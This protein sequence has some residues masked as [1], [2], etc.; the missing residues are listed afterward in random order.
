M[1]IS[2]SNT[3]SESQPVNIK[4]GHVTAVP[5]RE[6]TLSIQICITWQELADRGLSFLLHITSAKL[7]V[8]L[9]LVYVTVLLDK[10][11]PMTTDGKQANKPIHG[12][13]T[14]QFIAKQQTN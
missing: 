3:S 11:L 4:R 2:A 9:F 14:N 6:V 10:L 13:T 5:L 1:I 7:A 8:T 12:K